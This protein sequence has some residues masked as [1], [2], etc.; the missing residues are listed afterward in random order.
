MVDKSRELNPDDVSVTSSVQFSPEHQIARAGVEKRT[1]QESV[2]RFWK[3]FYDPNPGKVFT[4]LPENPFSQKI[5]KAP[6]RVAQAQRAVKSYEQAR[7][8]CLKDVERIARECRRGNRKYRDAH[9]DIEID[10]KAG[11]RNC[12]EGLE[13]PHEEYSPK[14]VKRI[15]V[16][17]S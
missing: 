6:E 13:R 7:E 17:S 15:N 3:K 5:A 10:L 12:L 1:P 9:F 4:V 16:G 14:A 8:E 2:D 11:T